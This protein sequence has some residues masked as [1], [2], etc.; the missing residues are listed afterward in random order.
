MASRWG[1]GLIVWVDCWQLVVVSSASVVHQHAATSGRGT[2]A[3]DRRVVGV[4]LSNKQRVGVSS[5]SVGQATSGRG[6]AAARGRV[7]GHGSNLG[8]PVVTSTASASRR[9][10]A[11][12]RR[13]RRPLQQRSVVSS[14]SVGC[15]W[16]PTQQGSNGL[17]SPVTSVGLLVD[18][19]RV[20]L[21]TV[22][23]LR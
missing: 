21:S 9:M 13:R 4:G 6:T 18:C 20:E 11:D 2:A 16:R 17:L 7:G 10:A 14:A 19:A 15:G 3:D 8:L 22:R 23:C 5:A 12:N 1:V